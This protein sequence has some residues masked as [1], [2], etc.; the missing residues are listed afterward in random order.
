MVSFVAPLLICVSLAGCFVIG[1]AA[2]IR[3][4]GP[5]AGFEHATGVIRLPGEV[6]A[7][8]VALFALATV[9]FVVHM[10]PLAWCRLP[11]E[12]A[13]AQEVREP[14]TGPAW[15]APGTLV[16]AGLRFGAL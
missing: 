13:D 5:V 9:V 3:M 10:L 7:T 12:G 14:P 15:A 2:V 6:T 1:L 4:A 11:P 16:R 8:I